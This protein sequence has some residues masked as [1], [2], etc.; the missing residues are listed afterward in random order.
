MKATTSLLAVR[1]WLRHAG[2]LRKR[3]SKLIRTAAGAAMAVDP[4]RAWRV[5]TRHLIPRGWEGFAAETVLLHLLDSKDR[6]PEASYDSM[7]A[8]VAEAASDMGWVTFRGGEP[9]EPSDFD[10]ARAYYDASRVW[11][12]CGLV[13]S[14][15][16]WMNGRLGLSEPGEAA[17]LSY[18]R[19]V[20]A[21]PR[22]SLG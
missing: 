6:A 18:L 13:T 14:Q 2:A 4:A 12:V 9:R 8:F 16:H 20:A 15:G 21:G 7:H 10:V 11:K 17:A 22:T 5:L 19:Y 1:E 3:K